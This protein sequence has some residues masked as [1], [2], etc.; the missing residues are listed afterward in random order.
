M[1]ICQQELMRDTRKNKFL[2]GQRTDCCLH[3]VENQQTAEVFIYVP[4][5]KLQE[6]V[7]HI[8]RLPP[9]I[10]KYDVTVN[11]SL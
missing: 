7:F 3:L 4:D 9:T 6:F 10:Q 11:W 1:C 5:H 8:H 2:T